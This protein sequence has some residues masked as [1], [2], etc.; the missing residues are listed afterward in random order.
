MQTVDVWLLFEAF[1]KKK[2][3]FNF[4]WRE[5]NTGNVKVE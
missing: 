5:D 3:T 1:K 4:G 2:V